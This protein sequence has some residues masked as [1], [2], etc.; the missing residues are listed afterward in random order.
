MKKPM[1]IK[2]KKEIESAF[3]LGS[4]NSSLPDVKVEKSYNIRSKQ[5]TYSQTDGDVNALN[6]LVDKSL[7]FKD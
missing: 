4:D 7:A 2:A 1:T 5:K 3:I 6:I